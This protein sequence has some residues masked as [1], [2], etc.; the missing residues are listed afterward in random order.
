[1]TNQADIPSDAR[2]R[3]AQSNQGLSSSDL[4]VSEFA[5]VRDAG[6]DPVGLV[7]GCSV[8]HLGYQP[9]RSGNAELATLS[10]AMYSASTQAVCSHSVTAD[11]A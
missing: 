7:L 11:V 1:V 6:F 8:F 4:S 2:R 9:S 10:Q 5:L 3:I